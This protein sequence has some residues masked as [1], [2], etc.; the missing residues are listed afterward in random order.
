MPQ[1]LAIDDIVRL[2]LPSVPFLFFDVYIKTLTIAQIKQK[3]KANT[4]DST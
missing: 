1:R 2:I 4:T 3:I